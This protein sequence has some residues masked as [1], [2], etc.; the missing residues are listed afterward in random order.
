MGLIFL[1]FWLMIFLSF[2]TLRRTWPLSYGEVVGRHGVIFS[3]AYFSVKSLAEKR[4]LNIISFGNRSFQKRL[5]TFPNLVSVLKGRMS[6]VGPAPHLL[7]KATYLD[8]NVANYR[9]RLEVK[10]GWLNPSLLAPPSR[11]ESALL[12]YSEL[13]LSKQS[14]RAD[15]FHV[16][17]EI[18]RLLS[19]SD[20]KT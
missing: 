4:C 11:N 13:Y 15:L 10:P 8:R 9:G 2:A 14:L 16:D 7:K 3:L 1:P 6:L 20:V 12:E 17:Q 5:L 19:W 18:R